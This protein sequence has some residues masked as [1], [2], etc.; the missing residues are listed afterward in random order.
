MSHFVNDMESVVRSTIDGLIRSSSGSLCRLDGYP[1]VKVVL[2][3]NREQSHVAVISGGGSGHEPAHAG[4]VG[5]GLLTAAVCG[6]IFASPS[7]EA[8][9][10]AIEATDPAKGCLLVIK[11]YTGDRLNFGLAAER[12]R[13]KGRDVATVIVADDAAFPDAA[14]RRGIAGTLFVHKIAGAAAASGRS[15]SEVAELAGRVAGSVRTIGASLSSVEIPGRGSPRPFEHGMVE[16]GLGI[17]GEPGRDA[18]AMGSVRELVARMAE[19]L[20]TSLGSKGPLAVLINN[21]GG[22]SPLEMSIVTDEFLRTDLG[23]SVE[24]IV[25]PAQLMTSLGMRGISISVLPI[26]DEL[27]QL[28][29]QSIDGPTAWP[30]VRT[31]GGIATVP[32]PSVEMHDKIAPSISPVVRSM[33]LAGCDALLKIEKDL[34]ELDSLVGDGDTGSSFASAARR[35]SKEI[36]TLPLGDPGPLCSR[37]SALCSVS[38]GASS[39]ILLSIMFAAMGAAFET[40]ETVAGAFA[41]GIAAMQKHGGAQEGDR[42]M[43]DALIPASEALRSAAEPSLAAA[44]ALDGAARTAR[45]KVARAG[46]SSY[47]QSK[48]LED[49]MDPGAVAV[50]AVFQAL[51]SSC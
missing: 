37:L 13:A 40:N 39:G 29:V 46:R 2:Q 22:T 15:L 17:H 47:I 21:L 33:I 7:V 32:T 26:D 12:A 1:D 44:A 34:N 18:S 6:E 43:L 14:Q 38:M 49:V 23:T 5:R 45:M 51:V 11:N 36:D 28:L 9:L 16:L 35:I 25:G 24:L 3:A 48:H 4:F 31:V 19:M 42:T 10:A 50:A 20:E 27:R 41:T 8:V 30:G